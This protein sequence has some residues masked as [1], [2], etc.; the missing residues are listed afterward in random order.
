MKISHCVESDLQ[1]ALQ[2]VNSEFD[3]N[4]SLKCTKETSS[5]HTYR[6]RLATLNYDKPG[7]RRS[8]SGRRM[9]WAC[10]H[11]WGDFLDALGK[12]NP[13]A[14]F[15]CRAGKTISVRLH[16][17]DDWNCGSY[18]SPKYMSECCDCIN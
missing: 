12:I 5:G 8:V 18:N 14:K 2:V 7:W 11:V 15:K 16:N 9:K 4:I 17:W 10:W 3:F 13:S 6:I 1:Q